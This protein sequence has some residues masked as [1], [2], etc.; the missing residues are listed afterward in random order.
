[1]LQG[2]PGW[3]DGC[4][5]IKDRYGFTQAALEPF[6][7]PEAQEMIP[8]LVIIHTTTWGNYGA[9]LHMQDPYLTSPFIFAWALPEDDPSDALAP[10]FPDRTIY[11]YYPDQPDEFYTQHLP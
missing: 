1:V 8:A 10:Y 11:H 5:V 9:Y 3:G 4:R 2:L 6:H 7:T